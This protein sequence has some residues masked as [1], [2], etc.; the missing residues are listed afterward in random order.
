[1]ETYIIE[2]DG[3]HAGLEIKVNQRIFE[4]YR[5]Q[6]GVCADERGFYQ[7]LMLVTS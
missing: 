5:P 2:Y 4:G 3:S 1:M 7:A 6:G